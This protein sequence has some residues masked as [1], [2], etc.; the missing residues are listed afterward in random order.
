MESF[1]NVSASGLANLSCLVGAI[2]IGAVFRR[3]FQRASSDKSRRIAV[4]NAIRTGCAV[5][6]P[7]ILLASIPSRDVSRESVTLPIAWGFVAWAVDHYLA[8]HAPSANEARAASLRFD[9]TSINSL[10]F[11]LC[12]LTGARTHGV[13]WTL[14]RR[15][16]VASILVALPTHNIAPGSMEEQVVESVQ[17][18]ILLWCIGFV[19][20]G[21][22]APKV[23][24][25]E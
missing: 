2:C 21:A 6:W 10:A 1:G 13:Q 9:P 17:K 24:S 18:G 11:G 8:N 20:A 23:V 7:S 22:T 14:F 4:S 19:I 12:G 3:D 25:G 15:A 16:I 5:L